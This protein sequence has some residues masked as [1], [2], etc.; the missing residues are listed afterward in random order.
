MNTCKQNPNGAEHVMIPVSQG[1]GLYL[2]ECRYCH[3]LKTQL[4]ENS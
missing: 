1:G 3:V 4:K 2:N